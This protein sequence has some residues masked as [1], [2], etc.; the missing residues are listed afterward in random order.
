MEKLK[1]YLLNI[2]QSLIQLKDIQNFF[3]L[4]L[5]AAGTTIKSG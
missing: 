4:V 1:D 2:S 5:E 3:A